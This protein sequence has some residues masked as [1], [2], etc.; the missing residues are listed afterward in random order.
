VGGRRIIDRVAAALCGV[1]SD[2]VL[3]TGAP[4]ADTWLP[5]VPVIADAWRVRGS[6]V[7]IHTALNH[8]QQSI[9]LAAWD[10]PF[11]TTELFALI[12]DHLTRSAFA[13]IPESDTGLEPFC[14][15]Y[16]PACLPAIE[17]ALGAND[18]RLSNL[19]AR[20][21]EFERIPVDTVRR[22]GDPARLFF[23]VNA[24]PDL[25]RAEL[26]ATSR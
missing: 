24:P 3:I 10:M 1:V 21:P 18:L 15:A 26:L 23:N 11:V 13:A 8:A 9:L 17:S 14:A 5:G 20:L 12:R 22:A 7:G 25:A 4:N 16:T 2:L 19:I 6:L